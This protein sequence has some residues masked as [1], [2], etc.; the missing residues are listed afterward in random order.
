MELQRFKEL[1][2]QKRNSEA[3]ARAGSQNLL[4]APAQRFSFGGRGLTWIPKTRGS[5]GV[6]GM[7]VSPR[8]VLLFFE[9]G[10]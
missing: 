2:L 8:T 10:C 7:D 4:G 5:S 9:G 6:T 3:T 1:S